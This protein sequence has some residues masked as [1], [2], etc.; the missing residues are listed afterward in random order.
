MFI[1][2]F[3]LEFRIRKFKGPHTHRDESTEYQ[4]EPGHG[5]PREIHFSRFRTR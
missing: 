3:I 1:Y 2:P 5:A 4:V